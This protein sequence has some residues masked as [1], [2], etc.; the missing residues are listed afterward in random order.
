MHQKHSMFTP[1]L[2]LLLQG[3]PHGAHGPSWHCAQHHPRPAQGCTAQDAQEA[4]HRA[5]GDS[6]QHQ[7]V[8]QLVLLVRCFM[9][10]GSN[11]MPYVLFIVPQVTYSQ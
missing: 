1:A 9:P 3:W 2:L 6:L 5:T 8:M 4:V 10:T 11:C 7:L